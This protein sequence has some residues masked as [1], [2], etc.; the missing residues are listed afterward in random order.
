MTTSESALRL[1]VLFILASAVSAQTTVSVPGNANI[2][3]SGFSTAPNPTGSGGGNGGGVTPI[4]YTLPAGTTIV[5]FTNVTGTTRF[6]YTNFSGTY[7][8][9]D[10]GTGFGSQTGVTSYNSLSGVTHT[11][12]TGFLVGVFLTAAEPSGPAPTTLTYNVASAGASA[13][14]PALQQVFFIGDGLDASSATQT[15]SVPSGATRLFLGFADSW[16]GTSLTGQ[17]GFYHDN[18]GSLSVTVSAVPEPS[19]WAVLAGLSV[20]AIAAWRRRM[21]PTD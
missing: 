16:D 20:M 9:P 11:E 5:T 19:A 12:R 18:D 3:G 7:I 4:S 14:S 21:S 17:P 15:F 2:Y 1:G 13:F 10:G 6:D 8:G